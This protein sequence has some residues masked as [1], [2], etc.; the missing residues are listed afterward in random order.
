MSRTYIPKEISWLSFNERVLQEAENKEVPLIERF[1][2]LGI[3]SN[4][5]DEYFR[6]RVA[7]LKRLSHLGNKSKDVLGYSPKATLKK[8]QKI[9]LEQN[10]KFE[11]IYTM[12]IQEL[13]K[14]NIHIINEK[15]L[16]HEQS[17]FVRSYFHSEVRTRLMPFLLEKDKEMPNLTDD[18]IYLAIILKKKDSDKTR[19]ALIEVPTNILPRLI[20]LPDSETGR[21]LIYLDD[22]IRFGLKDIF[23]IFDFDEFSAY[24]IK[25][26]KDAELEIADDISESYIE[27]LSKSLHQRKWGSPVRFIYDR[28]MP[29]DL[30]N[31]L[32]KK[33][34][35]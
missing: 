1:K 8:I 21:N 6:V 29:A 27:K 28:K 10:T 30:L 12:L 32:T 16:N 14:H 2:F 23:F 31:I 17:E 25:L 9:V 22:I 26:T 11:K 34:N 18:A 15:Q 24:T 7:T 3:Y 5:L 19:Y 4:N 13:A 35:F 33:L 20:I